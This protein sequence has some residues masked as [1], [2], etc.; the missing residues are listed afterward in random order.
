MRLGRPGPMTEVRFHQRA[1]LAKRPMVLS[2]LEERV[3]AEPTLPLWGHENA[4]A[5]GGIAPGSNCP[6][7]IG[8]TH[9]AYEPRCS[10]GRRQFGQL[11][12]QFPVIGLVRSV[13]PGIAGRKDPR[14]AL[15]SFHLQA[16]IVRQNPMAQVPGLLRCFQPC[17]R[18]KRL[19]IFHNVNCIGEICQSPQLDSHGREQ[20]SQ[21]HGLLAVG[22][23][24]HE[25]W[26]ERHDD[27]W[28]HP[29]Q[30]RT[31]EPLN[32]YRR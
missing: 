18:G 7:W 25:V 29:R 22:G 26:L 15:E 21:F 1:Q 2:N 31:S 4:T 6:R 23:S 12:E 14:R 13:C 9:V 19:S 10:R 30:D 28:R 16:A 27:R 32:N 20:S 5:A 17:I 8:Q 24:E 11:L 3:V